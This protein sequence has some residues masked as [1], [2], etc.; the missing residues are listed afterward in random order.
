MRTYP[1]LRGYTSLLFIIFLFPF[2]TKAQNVAINTDGST[3]DATAILDVKSTN[4]GLLVPRMTTTQRTGIT[5]PA[6]GLLVFDTDSGS[7][8]CYAGGK[9]NNLQSGWGLTGNSGTS[10]ATNFIGTTDNRPLIFKVNNNLAGSIYPGFTS[11]SLGYLA[12][13]GNTTGINNTAIGE[14]A[15]QTNTTA[16]Y[17]TA[18]GFNALF[19]NTIGRYNTANGASSMYSNISGENNTA[20]GR[21]SLYFNTTGSTNTA[22]GDQSLD[23]NTTGDANTAV[24]VHSIRGNTTG[25]Y[26][27]GIGNE[28]LAFNVTGIGNTAIGSG[29]SVT[30]SNLQNATAIGFN[31]FV[32]SSNK[33]RIGN[34]VVTAIEGQ[35]PFTSPSDGRYKYNVKE[36]I[37]G[38]D[39][40]LR[41]RP[42]SYNFDV[43]KFDAQY[44][45]KDEKVN[46][47]MQ[48][49]YTKA[50]AIRRTG[51]IAQEV[52]QAADQSG[53]DFSGII[54]PET[55]KDHYSLSYESFVVPMVKAIQE[56]S[57]KADRAEAQEKEMA[58]LRAMI[59]ELKKEITA[60]K[61]SK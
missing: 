54:K 24:G 6:V 35:V 29:A 32:S 47:F 27:T 46:D 57:K 1:R 60:L 22:V 26:N 28:A 20:V 3:P 37:K 9:W 13:S 43:K 55:E 7:F 38:L 33:V 21:S 50:S 34:S 39:F 44:S 52:E 51:F 18:T 19:N 23:G 25:N 17:N 4:K 36:D 45:S 2:L 59:I 12:L 49:S 15:L 58:E 53:Y 56:L 5:S 61:N 41:L 11:V 10:A 31:A 48:A 16:S 14:S 30:S 8:W 40:I 42:V